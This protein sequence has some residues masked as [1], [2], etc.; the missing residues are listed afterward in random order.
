M[1]MVPLPDEITFEQV[2]ALPI[3][4]GTTQRM[5]ITYGQAKS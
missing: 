3:A 4:S 5:M 2:A 1:T